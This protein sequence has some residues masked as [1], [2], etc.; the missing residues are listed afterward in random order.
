M[1]DRLNRIRSLVRQT[2]HTPSILLGFKPRHD[3]AIDRKTCSLDRRSYRLE[4]DL[5]GGHDASRLGRTDVPRSGSDTPRRLRA[6]G[7]AS[8]L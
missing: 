4:S 5:A 2:P 1:F 7:E 6:F 8:G 3:P